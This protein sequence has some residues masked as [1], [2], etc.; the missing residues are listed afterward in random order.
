MFKKTTKTKLGRA[1][2]WRILTTYRRKFQDRVRPLASRYVR[3]VCKRTALAFTPVFHVVTLRC[4]QPSEV[5]WPIRLP[6]L[7]TAFQV[8]LMPTLCCCDPITHK[9][10]IIFMSSV[11]ADK[12]SPKA[13]FIF[14]FQDV[15]EPLR[16]QACGAVLLFLPRPPPTLPRWPFPTN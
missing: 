12:W 11:R 10:P 13:T 16:N 3:G 14:L 15:K 7:L 9:K 6:F 2:G 5:V 1:A 4:R 8:Y